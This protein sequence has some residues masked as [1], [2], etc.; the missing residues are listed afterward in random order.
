MSAVFLGGDFAM[1]VMPAFIKF[2]N[3]A[4]IIG[5]IVT[6]YG[7]LEFSLCH[8]VAMARDDLDAVFKSL[9]RAR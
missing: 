1:T 7:E 8:C 9:F 6:G 2:H 4:A 5:R 3:E